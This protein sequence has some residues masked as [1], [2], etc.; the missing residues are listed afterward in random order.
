MFYVSLLLSVVEIASADDV[1]SFDGREVAS[2]G[3]SASSCFRATTK[4][5]DVNA[6]CITKQ[7]LY[8]DIG[9][10]ADSGLAILWSKS[11]VL[12]FRA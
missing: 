10:L 1:E 12:I 9:V 8:E 11:C 3:H 4:F 2:H 5:Y 7:Y 6:C